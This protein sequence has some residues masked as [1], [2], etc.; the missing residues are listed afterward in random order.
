MIGAAGKSGTAVLE[1]ALADGHDVTTFVHNTEGYSPGSDVRVIDGD[2]RDR[3]AVDPAML[4]Q[5]A[6]IDTIG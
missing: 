3:S 2:A 6:V 5:H 1:K 4:G